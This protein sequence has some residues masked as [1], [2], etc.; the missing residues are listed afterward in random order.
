MQ[1]YWIWNYGDYEVYHTNLVN[2]RRQ[3][4]GVDYPAFWKYYDVDR[5]VQF[6]CE[7]TAETSG[8][9][10]LHLHGK[11]YL[12]VDNKR[13]RDGVS[14][15]IG[16]GYH[17][18]KICVC[19]LTGLPS[20]YIESDVCSTNKNWYTINEDGDKIPVGCEVQYSDINSSPEK[21]IF[22]YRKIVP[23]TATNI[24]GGILYD[25]GKEIF[26]FLNIINVSET[27][28]L[29]ISYEKSDREAL[30]T[31]YSILFEDVTGCKKYQLWQRGFRYIFLSGTENPT[32]FAC[33]WNIYL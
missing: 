19:N 23:V 14:A 16:Q 20:A 27:D 18:L 1:S 7:I 15:R 30:D 13:I 17:S 9:I 28:I 22:E 8:Y 10:R 5:S 6:F 11:G 33:L 24:N 32:V 25:F 3:E 21:F 26:G 4:Y 12:M 29:H 31:Q 2:S